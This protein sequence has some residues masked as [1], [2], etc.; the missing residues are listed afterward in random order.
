MTSNVAETWNA[1][2]REAREFPITHLLEFIRFKLMNWFAQ[3]RN[4]SQSG[5]GRLTPRVKQIVEH[6]FELSG[7][8]LVSRI[9]KFEYEVKEKQGPAYHVNLVTKSCSC[10]SFQSLLIPCPHAI[11]AAI[12]EKS[13]IEALVSEFYTVETLA[14]AYSETIVPITTNVNPSEVSNESEGEAIHIFPPSSRR[15]P[16][17]PRKSRILSTGEIRVSN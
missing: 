13:S 2:L 14:S 16:G 7:G 9:N 4:I 5:N 12:K 17:R 11:A 8:M 10:F 15:P 6:N 3:R 1:V